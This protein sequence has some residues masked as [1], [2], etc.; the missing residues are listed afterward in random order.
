MS[1][2][3][4]SIALGI[5]LADGNAEVQGARSQIDVAEIEPFH[6]RD[7]IATVVTVDPLVIVLSSQG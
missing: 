3:G 1:E 7:R 6:R 2:P 4:R 5:G